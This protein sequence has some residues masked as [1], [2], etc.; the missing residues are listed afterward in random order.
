MKKFCSLGLTFLFASSLPALS[1]AATYEIEFRN[2]TSQLLTSPVCA[3]HARRVKAFTLGEQ[4]SEGLRLL[5][6]DGAHGT[7]A[8]ELR[9]TDRVRK[10]VVGDFVSGGREDTIQIGSSRKGRLSCVFGMLVVSNDAFPAV[11]RIRLPKN[12][13]DSRRI[14]ARVYD[15]GTEVNTESCDDVPGGPCD[16]HFTGQTENGTVQRHP[17]LTG[18]G[19]LD[20]EQYG[21]RRFAVRGTITR[22]R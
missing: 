9:N 7:F 6:E 16:A 21:W 2:R 13:G 15:A 10:V 19:D 5:A 8:S 20:V 3:L 4:A 1:F 22:I 11:R 14:R 17:G 18:D 12:V